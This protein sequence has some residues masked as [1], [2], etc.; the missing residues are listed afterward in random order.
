MLKRGAF[1]LSFVA[2]GF[3]LASEAF[4]HQPQRHKQDEREGRAVSPYRVGR[5]YLFPFALLCVLQS[6]WQ[7]SMLVA[8]PLLQA[9]TW[10]ASIS[11]NFQMR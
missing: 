5:V 8:P 1:I 7:F 10:S 4:P 11:S 9:A 6:I 2:S 3:L